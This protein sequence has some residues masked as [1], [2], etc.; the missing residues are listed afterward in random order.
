M[1]E[2]IIM[3]PGEMSLGKLKIKSWNYWEQ[4]SLEMQS[5]EPSIY[6]CVTGWDCHCQKWDMKKKWILMAVTWGN[7]NM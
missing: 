1:F 7:V 5:W 3:Y 6:T 4:S 2:M